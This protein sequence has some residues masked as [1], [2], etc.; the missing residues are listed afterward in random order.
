[1]CARYDTRTFVTKYVLTGF[2]V[3]SLRKPRLWI[4]IPNA[5]LDP[6]PPF[7]EPVTSAGE[8][9]ATRQGEGAGRKA[10]VTVRAACFSSANSSW[11]MRLSIS[12]GHTPR[13]HTAAAAWVLPGVKDAPHL[14][15]PRGNGPGAWTRNAVPPS[16]I[17]A[18]LLAPH[19]AHQL[20]HPCA[21]LLSWLPRRRQ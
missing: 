7:D 10:P 6:V 18:E 12:A 15:G 21:G 9:R 13:C 11:T 20:G 17:G 1:M 2:I 14:A 4:S 16:C 5:L 19:E 8:L 3:G